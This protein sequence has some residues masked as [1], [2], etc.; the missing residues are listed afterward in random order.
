MA[1]MSA[2]E[3]HHA[4]EFMAARD[5][6]RVFELPASRVVEKYQRLTARLEAK[7]DAAIARALASGVITPEDLADA[8]AID[9]GDPVGDL[10]AQ[11]EK[12]A[13]REARSRLRV[14]RN[15]LGR[16]R[17]HRADMR[18]NL[19]LVLRPVRQ[20]GAVAK[21]SRRNRTDAKGRGR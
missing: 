13:R 21:G 7:A 8:L 3:V 15:S 1:K 18:G 12:R 4:I 20:T 19:Q 10:I 14:V 5:G 17:L 11:R 2:W 16:T 6:E 9:L